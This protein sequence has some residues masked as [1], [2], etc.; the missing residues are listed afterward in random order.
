MQNKKLLQKQ[1]NSFLV[2]YQCQK[3]FFIYEI[4]IL[5]E[6]IKELL[7]LHALKV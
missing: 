2:L 7:I 4:T 6:T 3:Y 1:C 5:G